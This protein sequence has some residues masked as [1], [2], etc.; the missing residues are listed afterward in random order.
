MLLERYEIYIETDFQTYEFT[1]VY[2]KGTIT[3]VVG[4]TEMNVKRY[5]NLGFGD[6]T[7]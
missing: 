5:Y 4:Y 7:L 3:N 2:S 1:S 6:K